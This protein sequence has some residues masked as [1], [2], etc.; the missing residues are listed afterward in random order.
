MPLNFAYSLAAGLLAGNANIV[1]IPS[2]DFPQVKIVC[3]ALRRLLANEQC[4]LRNHI[5]LARYEK[6]DA[7]T[8]YFSA[9]CDIRVIWGG[10]QTIA[11]IRRS[12]VKSF[13]RSFT[14]C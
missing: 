8:N 4:P 5:V 7:V 14:G 3:A 12:P 1:R 11:D 2:R 6:S 10:D 13:K 9:R